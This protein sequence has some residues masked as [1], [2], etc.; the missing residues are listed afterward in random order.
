MK[1][2]K[3]KIVS[4]AV[5]LLLLAVVVM[6]LGWYL[7]KDPPA[8]SGTQ[9]SLAVESGAEEW[10]GSLADT[11]QSGMGGTKIP[12][13]DTITFPA[14]SKQVRLTLPNDAENNCY[15][16]YT[17]LL[18]GEVLYTS[19]LI[20]PGKAVKDLKLNRSLEQGTYQLTIQVQP[21]SLDDRQPQVNANVRAK[22]VVS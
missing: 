9:S 20:E 13:Y 21:Y 18:E 12:G 17:L 4:A 2:S 3:K 22:L 11:G 8:D 14:D 6:L 16:Q 7:Q 5:V 1:H 15:L 19:G 10:S